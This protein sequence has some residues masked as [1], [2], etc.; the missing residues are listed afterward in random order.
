[1]NLILDTYNIMI[2][3]CT[4]PFINPHIWS[5]GNWRSVSNIYNNKK[6]GLNR[7]LKI[8]WLCGMNFLIVTS[9]CNLLLRNLDFMKGIIKETRDANLSVTPGTPTPAPWISTKYISCYLRFEIFSLSLCFQCPPCMWLLLAIICTLDLWHQK[10]CPYTCPNAIFLP[11]WFSHWPARAYGWS[12]AHLMLNNNQSIHI[13][14]PWKYLFSSNEKIT[15][16]T[17]I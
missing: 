7:N 9:F 5:F 13:C 10:I 3:L 17:E 11:I 12:T 1:M 6:I 15:L 16:C 14:H 2:I 4:F 8:H